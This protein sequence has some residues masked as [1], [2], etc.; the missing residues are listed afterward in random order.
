MEKNDNHDYVDYD[1]SIEISYL[2][3]LF[4]NF[5]Y[6]LHLFNSLKRSAYQV[7]TTW[8]VSGGFILS[9]DQEKKKKK[10]RFSSL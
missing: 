7:L 10:K 8:A 6:K 9:R 5:G 4:I 3:L 1:F 2:T